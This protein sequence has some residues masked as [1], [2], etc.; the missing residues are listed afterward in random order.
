MTLTR[1]EIAWPVGLSLVIIA[2]TGRASSIVDSRDGALPAGFSLRLPAGYVAT[3]PLSRTLDLMTLMSIQQ[4][5]FFVTTIVVIAL[6]FTRAGRSGSL[7]WRSL[8]LRGA[9]GLSIAALLQ[10]AAIIAPRPMAFLHVDDPQ[11]VRIDFHSHTNASRDANRKFSPADN[12]EWHKSGGFDV[13]YI[14]D[15]VR[16]GGAA[17]AM[18]SNPQLAGDS[19][20]VLSAVEGRYHKILSNI[21][22]GL[23]ARDS[24]AI[25][26]KGHLLTDSVF[27]GR[28][29]VTIVAIPNG[30]IDSV[31]TES[32]DS[33][34]HFAAMELVDAA[35]RGLAQLD[36]DERRIRRIAARNHLTLVASSNNH[37]WGRTVAAWS[38]M[39]I[40]EWKK[41]SPD[42]LAMLIEKPLRER[43]TS[44]VTIVKRLRPRTHGLSLPLT[45]PIGILQIIAS[46]T[47]PERLVWLLWILAIALFRRRLRANSS[48]KDSLTNFRATTDV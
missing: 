45:F 42:S 11:T 40:P 19:L 28:G 4:S 21:M 36:S 2:L 22:L 46:L 44:A 34:P 1:R 5:V 23:T 30:N 16:F 13:A 8:G 15:H 14:S 9:V 18:R 20:V 27:D 12:R 25:D 33:V 48:V 38:L 35:P 32:L 24:A 10:L 17:D 6:C 31:T 43:N 39:S 47:L 7:S 3:S 29:P 37:G 26:R 41:L